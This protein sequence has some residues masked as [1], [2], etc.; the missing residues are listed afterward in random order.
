MAD[1]IVQLIILLNSKIDL[2]RRKKIHLGAPP[3]IGLPTVF[4]LIVQLLGHLKSVLE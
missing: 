1:L 3:L 4:I 2:D